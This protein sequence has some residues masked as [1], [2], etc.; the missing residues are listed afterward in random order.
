VK[1]QIEETVGTDAASRVSVRK[2]VP[3]DAKQI[4][5]LLVKQDSHQ[6]RQA[7]EAVEKSLGMCFHWTCIDTLEVLP[8]TINLDTLDVILLDL[9]PVG[10]E[11]LKALSRVGFVAPALPVVALADS[12]QRKLATR[13]LKLGADELLDK[14]RLDGELLA[15]TLSHMC[16]RSRLQ[17]ALG[18][19]PRDCR[20]GLYNRHFFLVMAEQYMNLAGRLRGM[21]AMYAALEGLRLWNP[22]PSQL[23]ERRILAQTGR[24]IQKSFRASDL[25]AH[26][27]RCEFVALALDCEAKNIPL[28]Q[29]RLTHN[30]QTFNATMESRC[31]I[32][33]STGFVALGPDQEMLIG[34]LI[35][36]ADRMRREEPP[37]NEVRRA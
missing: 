15:R 31:R 23:E 27:G 26:W 33:L 32:T 21:V 6:I 34:Q 4:H 12:E 35:S 17:H 16:E 9:D 10:E 24:I 18:S 2:Q 14:D 28:F 5:V 3:A 7:V 36:T 1:E 37:S 22:P 19:L 30:V 25:V 13:G 11:G 8:D 20:T 29:E